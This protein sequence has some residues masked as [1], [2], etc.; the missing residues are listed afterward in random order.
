MGGPEKTYFLDMGVIIGYLVFVDATPEIDAFAAES[1]K[2]LEQNKDNSIVTCWSITGNDLP[3]FLKRW[4]MMTNE[5]RKKLRDPNYEISQADLLPQDIKRAE[6]IYSMAKTIG[7]EKLHQHLIKIETTI[8]I[9]LDYLKNNIINEVVIPESEIDEDLRSHFQAVTKN[10][11]DSKVIAS[12]IQYNTSKNNNTTIVT[13]D[14]RDFENIKE[15]LEMR[16]PFDKY[17]APKVIFL[18]GEK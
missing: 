3:K 15:N 9:R 13:T 4:K 18:K 7:K 11:S 5:I 17:V 12:A 1:I 14:R 2:F 8:E 10:Y 6:R 16:E